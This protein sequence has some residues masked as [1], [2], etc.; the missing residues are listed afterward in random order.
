[1]SAKTTPKSR[2]PTWIQSATSWSPGAP[3]R[4]LRPHLLRKTSSVDG[5]GVSQLPPKTTPEI[6][7][8][9]RKG[10]TKDGCQNGKNPKVMSGL[11]TEV[12]PPDL[13]PD[14]SGFAKK[15]APRRRLV[16]RTCL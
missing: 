3:R 2:A 1:M 9:H 14:R 10:A 4:R 12:L 7:G 13:L 11:W 5:P 16:S 8:D 6:K 15:R